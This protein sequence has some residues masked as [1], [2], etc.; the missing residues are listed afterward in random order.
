VDAAGVPACVAYARDLCEDGGACAAVVFA[1]EAEA[2]AGGDDFPF[3]LFAPALTDPV[4]DSATV[5][6]IH[7]MLADVPGVWSCVGRQPPD[8]SPVRVRCVWLRK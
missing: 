3:Y 2:V 5:A 6:S 4:T 8:A 1:D 7:H